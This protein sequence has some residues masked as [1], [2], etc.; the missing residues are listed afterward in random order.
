M[1][2]P[3]INSA[4]Q[5]RFKIF[6]AALSISDIVAIAHRAKVSASG[7]LGVSIVAIGKRHWQKVSIASSSISLLP[8][9]ETITGSI[10]SGTVLY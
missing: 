9:V 7:M 3:F 5:P 4:L 1:C 10:T 6:I 8:D 2:P